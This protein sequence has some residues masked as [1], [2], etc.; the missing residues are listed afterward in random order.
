MPFS[1]SNCS[2]PKIFLLNAF[3][4]LL[5]SSSFAQNTRV[6]GYLPSYRFE[7][8]P[9]IEYCKLTHLNLCFG[10][11]DAEGNIIMQ[12]IE[13]VMTDAKNSNP[14]IIIMI[15]LAGGY[16]TEQ[17]AANWSNLIDIPE[18]RPAF[19]AKIVDY[20]ETNGLDGVDVD[21]E[22]DY[23]TSGYSGFVVELQ[24]ALS[25]VGKT[26]TAA[27][28]NQTLFSNISQ[29]AL[30]AFEFINIMAYDATGP[31]NPDVSGQHSSYDFSVAGIEFWKDNVGIPAE[32]LNLGLPFYGYEFVNATT[33]NSFTYADMV[34]QN[35]GYADLDKVGNAYY[36]GRPTIESKVELANSLVGGSFVWEVGQDTY[37]QYSLLKTI[38]DKYTTLG[39]TTTGLC[40][41]EHASLLPGLTGESER[42]VS[43]NPAT[44]HIFVSKV[45]LGSSV[46]IYNLWGQVLFSGQ[47]PRNGQV[48]VSNLPKGMYVLRFEDGAAIK[49]IKN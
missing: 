7:L 44:D 14:D 2:I 17:Q 10:N 21:L 13:D 39:I 1:P 16:L 15:S 34:N 37:D 11:P 46:G 35:T 5:A 3:I 27:L 30:N 43:P 42:W 38:H 8:S 6:L 4:M 24:Q 31:W 18:N 47:L 29:E 25:A 28:P 19:I 33:V 20:V 22:W 9:Q 45:E 49:F 23:V 26:T 12:P 32:K 48:M 41:N 40:G 36:N